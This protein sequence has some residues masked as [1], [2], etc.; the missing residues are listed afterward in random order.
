MKCFSLPFVPIYSSDF[1]VQRLHVTNFVHVQM[2]ALYRDPQG[3]KIFENVVIHSSECSKNVALH[4]ERSQRL[5]LEKEVQSL[6]TQLKQQQSVST[7]TK[8]SHAPVCHGVQCN[9]DLFLVKIFV[10]KSK[11][12]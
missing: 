6:Q 12:L 11:K 9:L 5:A 1:N 3:K 4:A 10:W 2:R 7:N 8:C